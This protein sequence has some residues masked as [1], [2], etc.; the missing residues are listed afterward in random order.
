[1]QFEEILNNEMSVVVG[2]VTAI[3]GIS[4]PLLLQVIER[5]DTKY[6]SQAI[7]SLL[8]RSWQ[9]RFFVGLLILDVM[10]LFVSVI[11]L[12][13]EELDRVGNI[14]RYVSLG[15]SLL[16]VL[17]FFSLCKKILVFYSADKLAA[18]FEKR[19]HRK[20]SIIRWL[21]KKHHRV[22][23]LARTW[24]VKRLLFDLPKT[25]LGAW[26]DFMKYLISNDSGDL[27]VDSY[28]FLYSRIYLY[29]YCYDKKDPIVYNEH[30][31]NANFRL[32][33]L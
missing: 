18:Y 13:F 29:R 21:V 16:L 22:F 23:V 32:Q 28:Q 14:L 33:T 5:I 8:C 12:E 20:F 6:N 24:L 27:I 30:I 2:I 4:Y 17:C 19:N 1:M 15:F 11:I 7:I 25:E 26:T 3:L 9:Y 10:L 31:N